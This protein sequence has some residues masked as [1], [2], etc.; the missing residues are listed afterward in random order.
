MFVDGFGDFR[1]L[2]RMQPFF[3]MA[4]PS[5]RVS[6]RLRIQ[7]Q[8]LPKVGGYPAKTEKFGIPPLSVKHFD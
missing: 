2:K 7:I 4:C 8:K 5:S 1:G 3:R 6:L